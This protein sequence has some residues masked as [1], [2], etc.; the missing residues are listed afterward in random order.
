MSMMT[1]LIKKPRYCNQDWK[2][3]RLALI[4]PV[5]LRRCLKIVFTY[6]HVYSHGRK[7]ATAVG[8]NSEMYIHLYFYYY[9]SLKSIAVS[10]FHKRLSKIVVYIKSKVD[11]ILLCSIISHGQPMIIIYTTL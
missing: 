9:S 11:R 2:R 10:F 7:S 4:G 6:V 1:L 5:V 8:R 3:L